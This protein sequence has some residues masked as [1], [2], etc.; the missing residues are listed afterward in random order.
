MEHDSVI[1]AG[2]RYLIGAIA[3]AAAAVWSGV[4]L[5]SAFV[6]L[7]VFVIALLVVA[8]MQRRSDVAAR[9][10][11]RAVRRRSSERRAGHT[12]PRSEDDGFES[13]EWARP[14]ERW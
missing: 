7:L 10:S 11:G 9:R 6:C 8:A 13:G 2:Q 14:A 1:R 4:G 5:L 12:R 3:F